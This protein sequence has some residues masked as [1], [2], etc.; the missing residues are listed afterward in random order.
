M[1]TKVRMFPPP[2]ARNS[3]ITVGSRTY[4]Q[5]AGSFVDVPI[6]D[7]Q[8][9]RNNGWTLIGLVGRTND[10]PSPAAASAGIRT[11]IDTKLGLL[12]VSDGIDWRNPVTGEIV[13]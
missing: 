7:M 11:Y 9:L 10:R 5:D 12:V 13:D 1:E 4:P 2:I 6:H 3:P 8:D